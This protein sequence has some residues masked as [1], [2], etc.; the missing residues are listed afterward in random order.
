M[1]LLK[2]ILDSNLVPTIYIQ[3]QY[4]LSKMNLLITSLLEHHSRH[5]TVLTTPHLLPRPCFPATRLESFDWILTYRNVN[6]H[7][8]SLLVIA[9]ESQRAPAISLFP[10]LDDLGSQVFRW[11][12]HWIQ[13]TWI[14]NSLD[15]G[16]ATSEQTF[17]EQQIVFCM[18]S[19]VFR[20]LPV[21]ELGVTYPSIFRN[22]HFQKI[23]CY[24]DI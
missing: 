16:K 19:L 23:T 7:N 12:H 2:G 14:S 9:H 1:I 11:H 18:K 3:S 6:W 4:N 21:A 24:S 8:A 20:D 10:F 5:N 17:H 22:F 15:W 13:G